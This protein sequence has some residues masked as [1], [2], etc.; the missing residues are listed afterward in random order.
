VDQQTPEIQVS[1]VMCTYN[2]MGF[3]REQLQSIAS[4]EYLPAELVV[5]D[6][7]SSDGSVEALWAFAGNA[8]FDVRVEVNDRT[9]GVTKNFEKA[10][11]L[12]SGAIIVFADQDDVWEVEKIRRI[13]DTFAARPQTLLTFSNGTCID[14]RG[15]HLGFT[16]WD[17]CRISKLRSLL[18][19]PYSQLCASLRGDFVTGATMAIRAELRD[20][21]CPIPHPW[22]HDAWFAAVAAS[23]NKITSISECLIRYRLHS[24]Q[25]IGLSH[26]RMR[27]IMKLKMA[28]DK[29]EDLQRFEILRDFLNRRNL[30]KRPC[31]E[32][33]AKVAHLQVRNSLSSNRFRRL[34][35]I[36]EEALS[37]RYNRYSSGWRSM[38]LDVIRS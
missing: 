21:A 19:N 12:C 8:P 3:L 34:A 30:K 4:Q 36:G 15:H 31:A 23:E 22:L 37:G 7:C 10:V 9:L 27:Q 5:C 20:L 33:T 2:G 32:L 13:V 6:D 18:D 17:Q 16:L 38:I 1:V 26:G 14:D 24:A 35:Q 28:R 11:K 29:R 25:S